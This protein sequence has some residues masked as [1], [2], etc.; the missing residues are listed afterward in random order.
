MSDNSKTQSMSNIGMCPMASICKGM[1]EKPASG[2]LLMIPGFLLILAGVIII[3]EPRVL[4][5]FMASASILIG[6]IML[7][8]ASFLRKIRVHF[9]NTNG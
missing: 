2:F 7:F 4:V 6:V 8:L 3:L 5:W 1:A 9:T